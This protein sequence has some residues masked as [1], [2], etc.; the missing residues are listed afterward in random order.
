MTSRKHQKAVRG[1]KKRQLIP[2]HA[3]PSR[4]V[5]AVEPDSS[6]DTAPAI[7]LL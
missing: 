3:I 4:A 6:D 5:V 1:A 7:N 2:A